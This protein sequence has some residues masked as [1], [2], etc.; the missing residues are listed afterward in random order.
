MTQ[1][2]NQIKSVVSGIYF[3]R[4]YQDINIVA[5]YVI[6]LTPG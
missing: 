3:E 4:F 1:P 2:Y 5:C 6:V